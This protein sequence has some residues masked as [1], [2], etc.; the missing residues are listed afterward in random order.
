M[1]ADSAL[2]W[3]ACAVRQ[4][5]LNNLNSLQPQIV[6]VIGEQAQAILY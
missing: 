1:G 6:T 2:E 5:S 3:C 4:E